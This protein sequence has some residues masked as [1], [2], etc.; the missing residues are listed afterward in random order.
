MFKIPEEMRQTILQI[1]AHLETTKDDEW[2]VD[3]V[4]TKDQKQNCLMGHVFNIGKNDREANE[5]INKLEYIAT[6]FMYYPVN[7][8]K[9]KDYPQPTAKARCIAY[10]TDILDGKKK[11][12]LQMLEEDMAA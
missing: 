6:E 4:R 7:D 12:T 1:I 11:S 2:C 3:R 9:H 8:G 5:W 10:L